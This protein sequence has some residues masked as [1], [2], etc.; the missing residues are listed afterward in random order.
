MGIETRVTAAL[1]LKPLTYVRPT[2]AEQM[3]SAIH[4]ELLSPTGMER[5]RVA[6][7]DK[8]SWFLHVSDLHR[9]GSLKTSGISPKDPDNPDED[10]SKEHV[11]DPSRCI[12]CLR[13]IFTFDTTPQRDHEQIVLAI[14]NSDLPL[15]IGI[16]WSYT[17]CCKLVDD[18]RNEFR[19]ADSSAIFAEVVR[20]RGSLVSYDPIPPNAVR[21]WGRGT[22]LID[23]AKW[24]LISECPFS[25]VEVLNRG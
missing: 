15:R 17:G 18:L 5:A 14:S 16:D 24:P 21:V 12:V 10:F 25:E 11:R 6:I 9:F 23:P 22:P 2:M 8:H 13:P 7:I 4:Q 3:Q 1:F 19:E 20:R